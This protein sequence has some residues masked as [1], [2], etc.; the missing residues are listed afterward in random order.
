MKPAAPA[1][2]VGIVFGLAA[3]TGGVLLAG[4]Q[5]PLPSEPPRQ[6]GAGITPAYEGWFDN[7]DGSHNFLIGYLNRNRAQT[8][9][10]PI[11]P[12]NR[13][14]PGG[15]DL[16]QPTHFLP[17]RHV[18]MFM[19]TVPKEF[20]P[21][22]RLTW[23]ITVNGQTNSIPFRMHT[24]Y[25]VSPFA[26]TH[27]STLGNTPPRIKFDEKGETVTGP[28]AMVSRPALT[29]TTSVSTPLS[30]AFWAEDDAMYS[31]GTS[32][33]MRNPPPP[34]E[35]SW[36]KY[37]GPGKVT[38]EKAK[39]ELEKLAGGNVAEPYSGKGA[40]TARFSEP[41]E[42]VLH[43]TA[44]DYSGDGGGGEVCCWTSAMVKVTVTP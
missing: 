24:D 12:N 39:P 44:N 32:A 13:I 34:V 9:D 33:P 35:I 10:V 5:Q 40:T 23:T 20:T 11:G 28:V 1:S 29:R 42:Y 26:I 17:G 4:Q 18:G 8:V 43:M 38:F 37:R 25:N 2:V 21:Q 36:S 31:S 3:T 7:K 16:G 27:S 6:F 14:E 19:V 30:L 22:Q 41:G 15:P